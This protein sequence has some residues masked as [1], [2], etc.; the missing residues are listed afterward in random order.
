MPK[1]S[2]VGA[3]NVTRYR[4]QLWLMLAPFLVGAFV[5]VV[6]PMLLTVGLAFTEYDAL[7]A[8]VW[9]GMQNFVVIAQR[10]LFQIAVRNSLIYVVL[11]V[12]LRLVGALGLALL[13][14]RRRRG[15]D[16]YRTAVYLPTVIPAIAYALIWL[17]IYNPVYG[18]LNRLLGLVGLPEPAWLVNPQTALLA[19]VLMAGFQI[20]EGFIILLAGLQDVPQEYYDAA[21][22]DGSNRWMTFRRV[23]LPLLLPW[24]VLLSIRDII[25][26]AQQ[27]FAP[28]YLMT[29][30]GPYYATLF[31][32]LLI[33]EEAFDR[34]R[35]G[36]ASAMMVVMFI[37]LG[38]LLY[39]LYRATGGWGYAD[40]V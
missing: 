19:I 26:S 21:A 31:M 22:V 35:F 23:T 30:G 14:N 39:L 11:A 6:L 28:A 27:T 2:W 34:F 20:G 29:G 3:G 7:S 10:D 15:I 8:P 40:D 4:L 24:L 36:Q 32:P 13:L 12:P 37:G 38:L 1:F 5:L 18:P 33:F 9:Q 25:A 17:W 16:L